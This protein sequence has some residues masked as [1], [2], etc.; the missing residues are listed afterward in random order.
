MTQ[1]P[2]QDPIEQ[3][4]QALATLFPQALAG[5]EPGESPVDVAIAILQQY[6]LDLATHHHL[7]EFTDTGWAIRHPLPCRTQMLSCDIHLAMSELAQTATEPPVPGTGIYVVALV[8]DH[9][10]FEAAQDLTAEE[11]AEAEALEPVDPGAPT[12]KG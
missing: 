11:Q 10:V 8:D 2:D 12:P 9:L 1:T 7:I 3:L 4:T 5:A 6:A